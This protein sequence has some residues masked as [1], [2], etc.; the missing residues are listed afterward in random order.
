MSIWY[1]YDIEVLAKDEQAISKFWG[2]DAR[3]SA[4]FNFSFGAKNG[5]ALDL[6]QLICNNPDLIFLIKE[7]VECSTYWSLV[8]WDSDNNK[9]LEIPLSS[10]VVDMYP[11]PV[12]EINVKMI[13]DYKKKFPESIDNEIA[14]K[15]GFNWSAF[16]SSFEIAADKLNRAD[17][18]SD[19]RE[20]VS[21]DDE[22]LDY[23]NDYSHFEDSTND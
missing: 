3:A 1:Q 22:G 10:V 6:G 7:G 4:H 14:K 15:Y 8:R 9:V 20:L 19:F 16:F 5:P 13:E 21:M 11:E 18:Y 17:E 12:F 2:V 23:Q